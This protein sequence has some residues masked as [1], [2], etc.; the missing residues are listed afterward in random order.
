MATI[1]GGSGNDLITGNSEDDILQ[2]AGGS[3]E[4]VGAGGDD[5]LDGTSVNSPNDGLKDILR[6]G[7]GND[8]LFVSY[9][10]EAYGDSG[11]DFFTSGSEPMGPPG[12]LDGGAGY[13][14][15]RLI[16]KSDITGAQISGI[17]RL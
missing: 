1:T 14:T 8:L 16:E 5:L 11:D 9:Y 4:I 17:E 3:D 10:D 12:I 15:L 13:D 6:G 2:G 7:S